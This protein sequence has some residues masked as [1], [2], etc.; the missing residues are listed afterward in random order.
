LFGFLYNYVVDSVAT[1]LYG[2]FAW[3][4]G[5]AATQFQCDPWP[6]LAAKAVSNRSRKGVLRQH[7]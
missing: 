4:K 2:G 6:T 3:I 7:L 1:A 5:S